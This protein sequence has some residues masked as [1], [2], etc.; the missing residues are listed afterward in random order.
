MLNIPSNG[1]VEMTRSSNG[2]YSKEFRSEALK[3]VVEGGVSAYE[4]ARRLSLPKSTL[5]TG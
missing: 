4:A 1:G 2:R 5:E 3:L